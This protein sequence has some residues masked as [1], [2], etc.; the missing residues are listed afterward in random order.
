MNFLRKHFGYRVYG[1][2]YSKEHRTFSRREA[3]AWVSCYDEGAWVI[4]RHKVVV[5]RRSLFA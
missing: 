2:G 4:H 1:F 3:L 5:V